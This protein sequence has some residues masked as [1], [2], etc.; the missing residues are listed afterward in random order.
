MANPT[1]ICPLLVSHDCCQYDTNFEKGPF[2]YYVLS[3]FLGFL[4]HPPTLRKHVFSAENKQKL[5]FSDPQPLPP[6]SAYII[7]EWSRTY[8]PLCA[9]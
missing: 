2:I 5:P 7:Y 6:T 8:Y 3:T 1:L 9:K 4:D